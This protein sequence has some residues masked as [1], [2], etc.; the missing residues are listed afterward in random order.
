DRAL[1]LNPNFARGWHIGAILRLF[2][3]EPDLSIEH[4][5]TALRLSPGARVGTSL[6]VIGQAHFLAR[7][8]DQAVPKLVLAIQED[9]SFAVPYRYLAACYAHMGRLAEAREILGRLRRHQPSGDPGCRP[10]AECRASRAL[11]L[12]LAAGERRGWQRHSG[13]TTGRHPPRSRVEPP[14]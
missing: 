3:G 5:E 2:A 13:A 11:P 10:S 7:R 14:S 4:G 9:P 8:F 1:A 6:T 12:R